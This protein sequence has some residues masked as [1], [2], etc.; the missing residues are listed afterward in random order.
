MDF[1]KLIVLE[2]DGSS[3]AK[4]LS[5]SITFHILCTCGEEWG[6]EKDLK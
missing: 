6:L 2:M 1:N 4:I 3:S 5:A